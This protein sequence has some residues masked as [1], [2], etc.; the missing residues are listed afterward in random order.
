MIGAAFNAH[1]FRLAEVDEGTA[2]A[3]FGIIF[4][5]GRLPLIDHGADFV[6]DLQSQCSERG[7]ESNCGAAL[8]FTVKEV[9]GLNA[10]WLTFKAG[11]EADRLS[12]E[13]NLVSAVRFRATA[14][15]LHWKERAG[16]MDF[17]DIAAAAQGMG[18]RPDG[19]TPRDAHSGRVSPKPECA[20]S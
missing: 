18:I 7:I 11:F 4:S 5:D 13:L 15:I 1:A 8:L 16:F 6:G 14:F 3:E 20:I 2:V 17:D 10:A 19:E 9:A 12:A